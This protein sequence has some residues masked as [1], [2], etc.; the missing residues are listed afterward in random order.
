MKTSKK[1]IAVIAVL[2]T[3]IIPVM[4]SIWSSTI[5][6]TEEPRVFIDPPNLY[7]D[8][9]TP[10]KRFSI[11]ISVANV[12]DLKSFECKLSFNTEMLDIVT[13]AFLPEENLP[14]G[15]FDS[16]DTAGVVW[17]SAVYDGDSITTGV[18][19]AL[20]AIT[21]KM[22]NGGISP[23]N[24]YNTTL[25]DSLG[26]PIGHSTGDGIV[27]ILRHDIEV[28]YVAP[29][30][31]ETYVGNMV[32]VTVTVKNNG[33]VAENCTIK[34]YHN[35]TMFAASDLT[36]LAPSNNMTLVFNWN[37][38]D[39]AAGHSYVMKAEASPLPFETNFTNNVLI[40]GI[41]KVKIIGDVNNDD[42]VDIDDLIAWDAAYG[43]T[44]GDPSWNPQ[45]DINGDGVV[46]DEDGIIIIQHYR[47]TA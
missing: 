38:S 41:V 46:E 37:T 22:M 3:A 25:E 33:D 15:S 1:T 8:T 2:F 35:E 44:E 40:D 36:N 14:T 31:T 19:V 26:A 23:L 13:I 39:A 6:Q 20:V 12:T 17:I 27:Y 32:N 34:A 9:L 10:G 18:P 16:N 29:S 43:A 28:V 30:A 42:V 7:F 21:F 11:N 5:L 24:L 47:N 4:A 45:A